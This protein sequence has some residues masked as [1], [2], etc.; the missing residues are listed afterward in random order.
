VDYDVP[1]HFA[2]LGSWDLP[3]GRG[4]R[5]GPDLHP[6]ANFVL[7]GWNLAGNFNY[8]GGLPLAFPN[9]A[10]TGSG[11]AM[12][13]AA[14]RNEFAKKY[15][16]DRWDISYVPYINTALFPK[17]AGPAPY[18]LRDFPTRFGDVRSFGLNNLDLTISKEWLIRERVR[19]IF[20]AETM[21]SFNTTYFKS[22]A[23][24]NVTASNFGFLSQDPTLDPRMTVMVLRMTF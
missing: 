16:K 22:L 12:M 20:R 23:S 11:S 14:E 9:A 10:P 4:R 17:V 24:T 18:T 15:G 13:S 3:Y 6:I 7:G 21:N 8:R 2:I 1:T 19:F 5:W